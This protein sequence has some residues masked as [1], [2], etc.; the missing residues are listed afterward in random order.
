[1]SEP[2]QNNYTPPFTTKGDT[3]SVI[4]AGALIFKLLT[5]LGSR[6][7]LGR[8]KQ[9]SFGRAVRQVGCFPERLL[10]SDSTSAILPPTQEAITERLFREGLLTY[11]CGS[12]Y[13]YAALIKNY[14]DDYSGS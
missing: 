6:T 10:V 5:D 13:N 3:H 4:G 8:E 7:N 14:I 12:R 9:T 11:G 2:G 1:M